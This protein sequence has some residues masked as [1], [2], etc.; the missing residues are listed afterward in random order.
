LVLG[1][2]LAL[3][4]S[5]LNVFLSGDESKWLC[6]SV[7]FRQALISGNL[8][9][10]YQ[11]EHPGVVTMWLGALAVPRDVG[12]WVGLCADTG[13]DK[14]TRVPD[15][16]TL[17]Q[18]ADLIFAGRRGIA[19]ATWLG[20][21]ALYALLRKL[22]A[23]TAALLATLFVA[24]DP[25]FLA[26]SRVLHQDAILATAML[27][28]VAS[29]LVYRQRGGQRRCLLLSGVAG[30][31]AILN[32]SPGFFLLPWTALVLLAG[33]WPGE[34]ASRGRRL[35]LAARDGLLWGLV[36]LGVVV[37]LWP[38]L[39]VD[40]LDT[41][42]QVLSAAVDY[43][44]TPH[45]NSNFF[46]YAIR[47]DPGP[48]FY[49]V[50][51]ALR[52]TPWVLLGLGA[53][54]A[55]RRRDVDRPLSGWLALFAILYL[56]FMT[57]GAKKFDRYALPSFLPL[58]VLAGLGWAAI[59][60]WLA[61][62]RPQL[63]E[64]RAVSLGLLLVA[65]H[66]AI[67]LPAWPYAYGY[68]NPL[69]GGARVAPN[70][71]LIGWGEGLEQAAAY[72]NTRPNAAE[73]QVNTDHIA[74]FAP[75]FRGRT[76][77]A[78]DVDLAEADYYVF[79]ANTVQRER[80]AEVLARHHGVTEPEF[81]ARAHGIDWAYV[82]RNTYFDPALSY[83]ATEAYAARDV[84]VVEID[85]ALLR[86]NTGGLPVHLVG[87]TWGDDRILGALAQATQGRERVW[88]VT[89]A[90]ATGDGRQRVAHHLQAQADVVQRAE[91][92][93]MALVCYALR[94]DATFAPPAPEVVVEARL[95][96]TITLRGYDLALA[97]DGARLNLRLYWRSATPLQQSY[98]VFVH[99]TNA[100]GQL[101][102]QQDGPPAGG[103]LPTD[104][105]R[106]DE[107]VLDERVLEL[108][109]DAEGAYSLSV[110]MYTLADGQRLPAYDEQGA[111]L[112]E[113]GVTLTAVAVG[114]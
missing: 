55:L 79:Y 48:A 81:V 17:A 95:G 4:L 113:D 73:M 53:L 31:L 85:S 5:G 30:G 28:A 29:L 50:A 69:L 68:Y 6:R 42:R 37:A 96:E 70:I 41:L 24:L 106:A 58:D 103:A 67:I 87:S 71:L 13:G 63:G 88:L 75:F 2:S 98:M 54:V 21:V 22:V 61:R 23:P 104:T 40:P 110:G 72:L 60:S 80:S 45:G 86:Q 16:A 20:V 33:V 36:A 14:L 64:G 62:R 44:E 11:S 84:V 90:T 111:R 52:T 59:L 57:A 43:A 82:Y 7:N 46:W 65:L 32:K 56:G 77:S 26:L 78:G 100:A 1:L 74:Q 107:T 92:D 109:A 47:P 3:R 27:L 34:S 112:P 114:E 83:L 91:I 97:P 8:R 101:I 93:G 76:S 19:V 66:V 38:S 25:F 39:W 15:N 99:L 105:W 102:A 9:E 12:A 89:F 51:W 49:P 35:A 108:P 10:T 94:P 18:I